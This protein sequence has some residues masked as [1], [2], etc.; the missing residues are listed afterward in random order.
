LKDARVFPVRL[1]FLYCQG[2]GLVAEPDRLGLDGLKEKEASVLGTTTLTV[3][4]YLVPTV[5]KR[6]ME[7]P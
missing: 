3:L 1:Y 2:R 7:R 4:D 5:L 6:F